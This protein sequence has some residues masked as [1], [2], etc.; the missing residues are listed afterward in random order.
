[1]KNHFAMVS[2]KSASLNYNVWDTVKIYKKKLFKNDFKAVQYQRPF[3]SFTPPPLSLFC[4]SGVTPATKTKFVLVPY[5]DVVEYSEE[6]TDNDGKQKGIY[7][8]RDLLKY[9]E[10]ILDWSVRFSPA[11]FSGQCSVIFQ[12]KYDP[13][14]PFEINVRSRS[15]ETN[16]NS[17]S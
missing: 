10:L 14:F 17:R 8:S 2:S 9:Q 6:V 1:M 3:F 11:L 4:N 12:V 15:Y 16:V 5:E 13:Y 7:K